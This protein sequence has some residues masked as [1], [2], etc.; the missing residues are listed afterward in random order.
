MSKIFG[1]ILKFMPPWRRWAGPAAVCAAPAA[2]EIGGELLRG[3]QEQDALLR[4]AL[5]AVA[6]AASAAALARRRGD[7]VG[8]FPPLLRAA[9]GGKSAASAPR[10]QGAESLAAAETSPR[11]GIAKKGA[12]IGGSGKK[13]GGLT[14]A[15][16]GGMT[17]A[18]S[19]KVVLDYLDHHLEVIAQAEQGLPYDKH[20]KR[21]K[22]DQQALRNVRNGDAAELFGLSERFEHG[23]RGVQQNRELAAKLRFLAAEAGQ[24]E[25]QFKFGEMCEWKDLVPQDGAAAAEFY[26]RAAEQGHV[27]AMFALGRLFYRGVLVSQDL[28][29]AEKWLRRAAAYGEDRAQFML[30][31][32]YANGMGVGLSQEDAREWM[33]SR[34]IKM[35]YTPSPQLFDRSSNSPA[36]VE[37]S[38]EADEPPDAADEDAPSSPANVRSE[39][40][41]DLAVQEAL[42][43]AML[44]LIR[45]LPLEERMKEDGEKDPDAARCMETLE[46]VKE[47]LAPEL[48]EWEAKMAKLRV[49]M[50]MPEAE[51]PPTIPQEYEAAG[52]RFNHLKAA[53]RWVTPAADDAVPKTVADKLATIKAAIMPEISGQLEESQEKQKAVME[54]YDAQR[55]KNRT[56]VERWL[57]RAANQGHAESQCYLGHL[58]YNGIC[59]RKDRTKASEWWRCAADQ[60]HPHA[61]F[62]LGLMYK[63]KDSK[64]PP[65][66]D[67]GANAKMWRTWLRNAA[68]QGHLGAQIALRIWYAES[69]DT[70]EPNWEEAY[71]W[72]YLVM[73]TNGET[74]D[75]TGVDRRELYLDQISERRQHAV[76]RKAEELHKKMLRAR[77]TW[78]NKHDVLWGFGGNSTWKWWNPPSRSLEEHLALS[79][80]PP[81]E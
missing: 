3:L 23:E 69:P 31:H 24:M 62:K 9:D 75:E 78:Q 72:C 71:L 80:L 73:E 49:K 22:A 79:A 51:T 43:R 27:G 29:E 2:V 81:S 14:G 41:K 59:V 20:G 70:N 38:G 76:I 46:K 60:G 52:M 6:L 44:R 74:A 37:S 53:L 28:A 11:R 16:S 61:Q 18:E 66:G 56:E 32:M 54:G 48:A 55:E 25:A 67:A 35:G 65:E 1:T 17:E 33:R 13:G 50:G 57:I 34:I 77:E 21:R 7:E 8:M 39:E 10:R 15:R 40:E 58:Y 47:L 36:P 68:E 26:R 12:L 63:P 5:A 4:P 42:E 45:P 30:G 19:R 64:S